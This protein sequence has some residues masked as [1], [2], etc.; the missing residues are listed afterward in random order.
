MSALPESTTPRAGGFA[1][2]DYPK[3]IVDH[4]KTREAVTTAFRSL[5]KR[6]DRPAVHPGIKTRTEIDGWRT[7]LVSR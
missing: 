5:P 4:R 7:A 3:P 1:L 2:R 6:Q